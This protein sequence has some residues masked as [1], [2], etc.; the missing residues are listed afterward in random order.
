MQVLSRPWSTGIW[1]ARPNGCLLSVEVMSALI[2]GY[3]AL[4][5]GIGVVGLVEALKECGGYK[6]H[7]DKLSRMG[8]PIYTSH[9]ILS[10]NG[11]RICANR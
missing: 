11:H 3:H 8:V 5:A 4:Q 6:V 1:S 9:T 7:K 10:A 2:A